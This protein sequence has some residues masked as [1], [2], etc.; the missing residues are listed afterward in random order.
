M[1]KNII[2]S[3]IINILIF[4]FISIVLVNFFHNSHNNFIKSEKLSSENNSQI[5]LLDTKNLKERISET[6]I[7]EKNYNFYL[8]RECHVTGNMHD[9]HKVRWV[10]QLFLKKI[11]QN[12][13][14]ITSNS[15]YYLNIFLHSLLIVLSIFFISKT[16][17]YDKK[18]NFFFLLYI[19]FIFQ[20]YLGEYSFS[21]FEM[22][23]ISLALYTSKYKKIVL[24]FFIC[25]LATLNRESGFLVLLNWLVFNND[26]K[27][28]FI[29]SILVFVCFIII[30][31]QLI[32]CLFIPRFYIPL[33]NQTGQINFA[34]LQNT[35]LFSILKLLT[36]NF[37]LPFGVFFYFYFRNSLNNK[38]LFY[39]VLIYLFIFIIATP[40]HHAAVRLLIIPFIF[41]A[42]G[43]KSTNVRS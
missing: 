39:I 1:N 41:A 16:F 30:N 22:F 12:S 32:E 8:N 25:L 4:V 10:K 42:I 28:I 35:N 29:T 23:F 13:S 7:S 3:T 37:L 2:K 40:A 5:Y 18:Y 11:F 26:F 21:I 33:E 27:K 6:L 24:F 20:Q 38:I 31:F 9:R 43:L 15:P 17:A 36:V 14:N 34:D 19:T